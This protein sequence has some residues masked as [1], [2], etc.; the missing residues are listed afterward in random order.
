MNERAGSRLNKKEP[1]RVVVIMSRANGTATLPPDCFFTAALRALRAA[2]NERVLVLADPGQDKQIARIVRQIGGTNKTAHVVTSPE[3]DIVS[4]VLRGALRVVWGSSMPMQ[5]QLL[6]FLLTRRRLPLEVVWSWCASR[7]ETSRLGGGLEAGN[8]RMLPENLTDFE[9]HARWRGRAMRNA[10]TAAEGLGVEGSARRLHARDED[11]G[12]SHHT[13][14]GRLAIRTSW[15]GQQWHSPEAGLPLPQTEVELPSKL[16]PGEWMLENACVGLRHNIS[17]WHRWYFLAQAN[18]YNGQ[19]LWPLPWRDVYAEYVPGVFRYDSETIGHWLTRSGKPL[20]D[21]KVNLSSTPLSQCTWHPAHETGFLTMITMD[22]IFHALVH[23]VPLREYFKKLFGRYDASKV[24][25]LPHYLQYWPSNF[26][27]SIGW[28]LLARSIGLSA[29][30]FAEAAA[31]AQT[32][33]QTGCQCFS[34]LYGGHAAWNMPP[35]MFE[36]P[37]RVLDFRNALSTSVGSPPAQPRLL[38]QMRVGAS[39]GMLGVRQIVNIQELQAAVA[40]DP[41]ASGSVRFVVMEKLTLLEQY[42]LISSSQSL[43][44][45]HGQGLAWSMLLSAAPDWRSTCLEIIGRWPSF[46]RKDYYS[47]SHANGVR[48]LRL[49]QDNAPECETRCKWCNYRSCGNL[50]VNVSTVVLTLRQMLR[51]LTSPKRPRVRGLKYE[52]AIYAKDHADEVEE[53]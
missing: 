37:Q 38:F 44:G 33:S 43:A 53:A 3:A 21:E 39:H 36:P 22:N 6:K 51:R 32:F 25:L 47:T 41:L 26:S 52:K 17:G 7:R 35:Y 30:E 49:V 15:S 8:C 12:H 46:S 29:A 14:G 4:G 23:A 2:H 45:V 48:Y 20:P 19:L 10:D 24:H 27:K 11:G 40:A 13:C 9:V 50:T 42:T 34:R 31:R 18:A 5:P 16:E 28:Q 1:Y